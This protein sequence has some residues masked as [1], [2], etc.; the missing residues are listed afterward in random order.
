VIM[1]RSVS[2][3]AAAVLALACLPASAG[4]QDQQADEPTGVAELQVE[5]AQTATTVAGRVG[6][7]QTRVDAVANINP[8]GRIDSRVQ[9]RVQNRIRNR[10]DSQYDPMA[11]A[12]SPFAVASD[13]ARAAARR[14][15]PR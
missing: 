10:I 7:R 14:V 15:Q 5:Q 2:L 8:I 4:A 11:N 12:T 6:Q 1:L 3:R 9:N 13:E